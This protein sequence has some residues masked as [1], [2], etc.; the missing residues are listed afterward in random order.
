MFEGVYTA[1]ITPF[2]NGAIDYGA[3]EKLIALQIEG[4]VDGIVPLGTTGESPT[5]SFE[6]HKEFIRRVVALV[7]GRLKVIAGTGANSTREAI[8]LSRGAEEAGVDGVLQVNP[9]YNRPPQ[10][11]LIAHFE[12]VAKSIRIP[13]V[14]YNIP[15]RTGVNFLPAS[16]RELI[17]RVENVVAIKEAA[18]DIQQAMELRELCGDRLTLLSGDDNM[19]LPFLSIGAGGIVSVLSNI[20]P[21]D[22]KN[23]VTLHDG[24]RIQEARDLFYRLLPLCR[25]LFL[26]TNPIPIKAAMAMAG[27]CAEDLR[28]PLVPLGEENR[29][30]L[31]QSFLDYGVALT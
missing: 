15:G 30:R 23:V 10:R 17:D 28:L 4:G 5:V 27:I 12:S 14:L 24:G 2:R 19:L 13:V 31:R 26:E 29:A 9:Y 21:A 11:G 20:L 6:E 3:L 7:G 8:W 22:V 18:G 16:V 1:L 25:A